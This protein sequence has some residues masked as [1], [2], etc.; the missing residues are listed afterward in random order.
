M[1]SKNNT[2]IL[3]FISGIFLGVMTTGLVNEVYHICNNPNHDYEYIKKLERDNIMLDEINKE[4]REVIS[5]ENQI[6]AK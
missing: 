1:N 3:L 5:N 6:N 2:K 4:L